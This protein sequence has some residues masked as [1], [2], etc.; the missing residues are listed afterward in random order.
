[1]FAQWF[2]QIESL[3]ESVGQT[4][5][6]PRLTGRQVY[7]SDQPHRDPKEYCETS[8][9]NMFLDHVIFQMHD[10][11][12]PAQQLSVRLLH[13]VPA[14]AVALTT[15]ERNTLV[16]DLARTWTVSTGQ[17]IFLQL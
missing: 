1:M 14:A 17:M 9:F 6:V 11:F 13:L 12:G 4:I 2:S 8:V 3:T 15:D 5:A 16:T 7:R 10:R